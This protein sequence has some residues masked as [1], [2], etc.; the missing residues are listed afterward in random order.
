M[1]LLTATSSQ[2]DDAEQVPAHH[3]ENSMHE[4]LSAEKVPTTPRANVLVVEDHP[5]NQK[6]MILTL[7]KLGCQVTAVNNGLEALDVLYKDKKQFDMIYMDC[8]MPLLDGYATSKSIREREKQDNERRVPIV[9]L[10]AAALPGDREKCLESGMDDYIT[11]PVT[12]NVLL[13]SLKKW[14]F[15][16]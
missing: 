15:L 11:K 14:P 8:H 3:V 16:S 12:R 10:T 7:K 2:V 9:A 1:T 5:V 4:E 13:A 6:L